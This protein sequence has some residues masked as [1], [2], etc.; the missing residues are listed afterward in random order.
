VRRVIR[1]RERA[2]QAD[3]VLAVSNHG[4]VWAYEAG[5]LVRRTIV[6]LADP[7]AVSAEGQ[8][9][10]AIDPNVRFADVRID[11]RGDALAVGTRARSAM[12][13]RDGR[14]ITQTVG[15][16]DPKVSMPSYEDS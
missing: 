14:V 4:G 2:R 10:L 13:D 3:T 11:E 5:A 8:T 9:A 12:I 1:H 6:A 16:A 7:I 15:T